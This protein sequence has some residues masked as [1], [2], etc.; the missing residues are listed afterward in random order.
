MGG[1]LV[2][3]TA[4]RVQ[5]LTLEVFFKHPIRVE[6]VHILHLKVGCLLRFNVV[7]DVVMLFELLFGAALVPEII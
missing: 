6:L 7:I 1:R 4:G 3:G 2:A 5:I